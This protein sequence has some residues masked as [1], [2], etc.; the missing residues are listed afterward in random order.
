MRELEFSCGYPTASLKER[1]YI[2]TNPEKQMSGLL[3]YTAEGSEDEGEIPPG[4]EEG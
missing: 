1:L 2:S 4:E 3:I